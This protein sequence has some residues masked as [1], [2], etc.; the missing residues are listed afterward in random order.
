[1]TPYWDPFDEIRRMQD[2]IDRAFD[3]FFGRRYGRPGQPLLTT[4]DKKDGERQLATREPLLDIVDEKEHL[5][6]QVE[7]PGVKK[8]DIEVEVRDNALTIKAEVKEEQKREDKGYFYQE[9]RYQA[10]NRSLRL[11]AEVDPDKT[12]AT[13]T[14]GILEVVLKKKK[15][16]EAPKEVKVKI[17]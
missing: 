12:D 1:M 7:L 5:K 6:V 9:R 2:E 4:G 16:A 15:P 10:F 8:D 14:N 13:Y 3:G 17:K 11:P